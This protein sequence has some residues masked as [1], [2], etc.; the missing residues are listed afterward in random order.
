MAPKIGQRAGLI[1]NL[2]QGGR[3]GSAQ[4]GFASVSAVIFHV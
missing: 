2:L 1:R 4:P 3:S